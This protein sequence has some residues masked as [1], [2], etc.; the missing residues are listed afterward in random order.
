MPRIFGIITSWA[1]FQLFLI[2]R[3]HFPNEG[4]NV[5]RFRTGVLALLVLAIYV[6]IVLMSETGILAQPAT[7]YVY[8]GSNYISASLPYTTLDSI[9]GEMTTTSPL[10]AN[11]SLAD[12]ASNYN[13]RM[14]GQSE[15]GLLSSFSF[16]DGV[17]TWN[18]SN[19]NSS[20]DIFAVSTNSSGSI[21][22]WAITLYGQTGS[23]AGGTLSSYG[24]GGW[25]GV[26]QY[27]GDGVGVYLDPS[28]IYLGAAGA[29]TYGP[30]PGIPGTWTVSAAL[31][32]PETS[33]LLIVGLGLT[34]LSIIHRQK[35]LSMLAL[36]LSR[37]RRT[38]LH[39]P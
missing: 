29:V 9:S 19:A 25:P 20:N 1:A 37:R 27:A 15:L 6:A 12:I 4:G 3:R 7:T 14:V 32:V 18:L 26:A 2:G 36:S 5:K 35:P 24:P 8:Q 33:T 16:F 11:L 28:R 38:L 10:P 34:I 39:M 30:G 17:N 13:Y 31:A 22:A 21:T 23:V